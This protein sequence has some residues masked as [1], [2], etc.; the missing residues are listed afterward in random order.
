[1]YTQ[2]R[3]APLLVAFLF[4]LS[5]LACSA[6]SLL[7][8]TEGVSTPDRDVPVS[9]EA[10]AEAKAAIAQAKNGGTIR[11]T[12]SQFTSL[13][14]TQLQQEATASDLPLEDLAV[15]F[16]PDKIYLRAKASG[17]NLPA[18]GELVMVGGISADAG[19]L[20][21]NLEEAS[22][23]KIKLPSSLLNVLNSQFNKALA[24]TDISQT[25]VQ[26]ITIERGVITIER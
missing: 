10:A 6:G 7:S 2:R 26:S 5:S 1:M 21:L 12:E 15:W 24:N 3:W 11:L 22:I 17:D 4:L 25:K 16:E 14:V 13:L 18:S 8:R 9:D 20:Q 23:N 19:Q